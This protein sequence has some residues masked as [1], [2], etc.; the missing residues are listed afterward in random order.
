[1]GAVDVAILVALLDVVLDALGRR[2]ACGGGRRCS[3][4]VRL[5]DRRRLLQRGRLLHV[6]RALHV[7]VLAGR[8]LL[9]L[10]AI[11]QHGDVVEPLAGRLVVVPEVP[12]PHD[13]VEYPAVVVAL[14]LF[15]LP[16]AAQ[17]N[18]VG[19]VVVHP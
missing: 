15:K 1:M 19:Q 2:L 5:V 17:I 4:S 8:L 9:G 14:G 18:A 6:G 3:H 12:V 7:V 13:G 11:R 16:V 10:A